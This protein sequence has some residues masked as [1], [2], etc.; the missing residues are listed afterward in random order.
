MGRPRKYPVE[1]RERA[2]RLARE[3]ERGIT[4]G[5]RDLGLNPET[6]RKWVRRAEADVH[7][8]EGIKWLKPVGWVQVPR[9]VPYEWHL[10]GARTR[11]LRI[12]A[13]SSGFPREGDMDDESSSFRPTTRLSA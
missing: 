6:L 8:K 13:H 7:G 12:R 9:D 11:F 4:P 1:V 2:V 3:S 10:R 5:A